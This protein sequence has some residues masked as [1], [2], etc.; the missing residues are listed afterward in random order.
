MW[1]EEGQ[2][3]EIEEALKKAGTAVLPEVALIRAGH[4]SEREVAQVYGEDLYFPV[5]ASDI[6][7]RGQPGR[8]AA[9]AGEGLHAADVLLAGGAR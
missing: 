8:R 5:I 9:A 1:F 2:I 7:R 6:D 3:V 4:I